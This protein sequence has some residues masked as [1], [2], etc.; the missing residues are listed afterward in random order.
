MG[1]YGDLQ[2]LNQ[3][4]KES[5]AAPSLP[6][7]NKAAS[8]VQTPS[9]TQEPTKRYRASKPDSKPAIVLSSYQAG[10]VETL[11]K[12][13]KFVG[14][15]AFFGR[16]TPEEKRMLADA[17]YTYKRRGFKTSENEI[18][19]IAVNFI[20]QDQQANGENSILE[21]VLKALNE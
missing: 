21:Q 4:E 18:T 1:I 3:T 11:R 8:L 13:V 9:E 12:A 6:T 19:R 5:Q 16:F 20:L 17:A 15:E 10:I 14:K 2:K 7:S